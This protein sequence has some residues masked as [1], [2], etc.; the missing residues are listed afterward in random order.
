MTSRARILHGLCVVIARDR[1]NGMKAR[2]AYR[3]ARGRWNRSK[4]ARRRERRL[5]ESGIR[6]IFAIWKRNPTPEAF[7]PKWRIPL[8]RKITPAQAV[9][10]ARRIIAHR[11]SVRG[12]YRR[13]A[14]ENKIAFS[15]RTL[16]RALP[17]AALRRV[18]R[19]RVAMEKAERAALAVLDAKPKGAA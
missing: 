18:F 3:K 14:G 17:S 4:L 11:L 12:L 16:F 5:S 10:W 19:A 6:A 1:A 7:A 13:L 15:L 2:T 9:K 8:R